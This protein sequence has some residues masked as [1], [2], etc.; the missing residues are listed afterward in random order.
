M[1]VLLTPQEP[2]SSTRR[3]RISLRKLII[4]VALSS[5]PLAYVGSYYRLSRRGIQ[6]GQEYGI[7]G[8]LFVPFVEAAASQSLTRHYA[9]ATFYAPLNWIDR[10]IFGAPT[11]WIN[12]T[13]RLSG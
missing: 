1:R 6:E 3:L 13:W 5:L 11:P 10:M 4:L 12:I 2:T 8:F 7:D 9:L